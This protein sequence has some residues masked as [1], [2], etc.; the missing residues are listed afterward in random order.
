M[1]RLDFRVSR[2]VFKIT[3]MRGTYNSNLNIY[4]AHSGWAVYTLH[5]NDALWWV[6]R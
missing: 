2:K 4:T 3:Y 6:K 5:V 1:R